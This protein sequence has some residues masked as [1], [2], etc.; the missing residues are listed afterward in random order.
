[1]QLLAFYSG[2]Y[3]HRLMSGRSIPT[4][5]KSGGV[6]FPGIGLPPTFWPF[7]AGLGN[8]MVPVGMSFLLM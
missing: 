4:I 7:M 8:V 1:M 6:G 5:W 3:F 2:G